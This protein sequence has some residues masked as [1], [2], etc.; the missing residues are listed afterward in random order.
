MKKYIFTSIALFNTI[1]SFAQ[2][3]EDGLR[4][5]WFTG[6]GTARNIA[7]GGVM[8]SL[9][10]DITAANVN[11]AGLGLF[12]TSEFVLSPGFLLNQN[13]F[14]Y[15]GKDTANERNS[16]SYG[17]SGFI[18]GKPNRYKNNNGWVS[19]A[20]AISVNQLASYRNR[21]QF[22]GFN[23]TSSFSEQYLE[24]LTKDR[25]DTNAALSNYIFGSSLAFRTYLI[26]TL[27]GANGSFE[28]YQSLV[29]LSTGVNQYFDAITSGGYHEIAVSAAGNMEDKLYVGGSL[30]FP[31]IGYRRTTTYTE[32]DATNNPNNQFA[33]FTFSETFRSTGFG[34]GAKLGF[35]YKPQE[36]WRVG[37]ALHTPQLIGMRDEISASMVTNTESYAGIVSESSNSL[38]SGNAGKREYLIVTPYRLIASASYVFREVSDTRKQRAFISA[39]LEFVNYRGVRFSAS[40]EFVEEGIKTYLRTLNQT[41]KSV[42]KGNINARIGGELKLN[43]FMIRLGGAFFGSPYADKEIQ[44]N[45]ILATGGFGYRNHGIFIDLSYAHSFVNDAQFAY[46]L[47]DKPN[48][49]ATQ[50]GNVG[51]I[52]LTFGVKF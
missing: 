28:G 38:N 45:R 42:Y 1:L 21:V 29:P 33:S 32:T 19:S 4:T 51:N 15:R 31:I 5:A 17:A 3:P 24:E 30:T 9:G 43:V 26:D 44:A 50:T 2:L 48:T 7:T 36:F 46:R 13:K 14:N 47:S 37:F 22:S 6:N 40:D 34:V 8:G 11:P 10:G 41:V 12:K 25:A 52:M 23:N 35:I 39:D 27:R 49:F 16:F 18:F 20:F